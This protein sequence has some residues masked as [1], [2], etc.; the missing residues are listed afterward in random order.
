VMLSYFIAQFAA[1]LATVVDFPVCLP[2]RIAMF[3]SCAKT[4]FCHSSGINSLSFLSNSAYKTRISSE[5]REEGFFADET[6]VSSTVEDDRNGSAAGEEE[7]EPYNFPDLSGK[8]CSSSSLFNS[9][10]LSHY[11]FGTGK[12]FMN[13]YIDKESFSRYANI[14]IKYLLMR[15]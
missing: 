13:A 7:T 15:K 5:E 1:F 10:I 12:N 14:Y 2:V 11:N 3:P 8:N 4:F 9:F 6:E